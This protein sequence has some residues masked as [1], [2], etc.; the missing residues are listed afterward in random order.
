MSK[1]KGRKGGQG[2][3]KGKK[4][5]GKPS[6]FKLG[7]RPLL[8]PKNKADF[9][10]NKSQNFNKKGKQ[11]KHGVAGKEKTKKK[12]RWT[13]PG[14]ATSEEEESDFEEVQVEQRTWEHDK[15]FKQAVEVCWQLYN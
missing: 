6:K 15:V 1:I 7:Q 8:D 13:K 12:T 5:A 4:V 9:K 3:G 2:K 14:D 11:T 10:E